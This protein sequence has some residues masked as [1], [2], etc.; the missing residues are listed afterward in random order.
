VTSH[1][2]HRVAGLLGGL[3]L[4]AVAGCTSGA[5]APAGDLAKDSILQKV[6][7]RGEL[8]V[9]D[10]LTFAPFGFL[11]ASGQPQGYDVD[12]ANEMGKRLGVKVSITDTTS[13][14]RIPNLRTDKVDVVICNFTSNTERAKQIAFTDPYIVAGETLLVKKDSP[15]VSLAD[16]AGRTVATV[17]G[18][19]NSDIVKK[20]APQAKL[21][22]YDNSAAAVLAVRQ[23]QADAMIEDS[24]FLS[25]QAKLDPSLRVNTRSVSALE[26]NCFGVKQGDPVWL[27]W[28]NLFLREINTDG[29]NLALYE[30][31]FGTKP[32]F[33]LK[34][35][36]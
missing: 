17:K 14:N 28:L 3:V 32:A 20:Q 35:V 5:S 24:N 27:N 34:P 7:S 11:S 18:S 4:V 23:G 29:T 19:T 31:W 8:K 9:A 12:I 2:K 21:A 15:I 36:Y 22:E 16:T 10:C 30:K 6:I 25:Y 33:P 1:P 26:Y 13:A